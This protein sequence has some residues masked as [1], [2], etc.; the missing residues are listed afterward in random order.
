MTKTKLE[1]RLKRAVKFYYDSLDVFSNLLTLILNCHSVA[2]PLR[3]EVFSSELDH[4]FPPE[5]YHLCAFGLLYLFFFV[6]VLS[7][8]VW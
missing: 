6:N 1:N 7:T 2:T 3:D 5:G 8:Y 4:W